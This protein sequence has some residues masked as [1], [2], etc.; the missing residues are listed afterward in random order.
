MKTDA[1][2]YVGDVV[3]ARL[4]PSR[5]RLRYSVFCLAIDV[6][7]IAEVANR[8]VGFGY[9]RAA[10]VALHDSDLGAGRASIADH[11]R[12][13]F[14]EAGLD[15]ATDRIVLLTY[16]RVLGYVF[17]PISVYYGYG[18]SGRLRGSIYE[19]SNTF[20]ERVSYVLPVVEAEPAVQG[21][22]TPASFR[23]TC[24]KRMSVSPFTGGQGQ[25]SFHCTHPGDDLVV[26]VQFRNAAGPV[27]RTHFRG[28]Q[29]SLTSIQLFK[30]FVR[31]PWLTAKVMTA[32]HF[33][34]L[35]LWLKRVPLVR[36]HRSPAFSV[37]AE[38]VPARR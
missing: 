10:L 3:H 30:Q 37:A 13:T 2:L 16:P 14:C 6:D 31:V 38:R 29:E 5:H 22:K 21:A 35:R 12:R 23:Q 24:A 15:E 1:A 11:A 32:I 17:N 20:G 36:R 34:A 26:G 9:N 28:R 33:E 27:L 18:R 8:V 25:Y 7:C 4:L 19:V